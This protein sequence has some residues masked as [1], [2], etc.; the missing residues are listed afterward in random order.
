MLVPDRDNAV[1]FV[2]F[3]NIR[4][5]ISNG[6]NVDI[7][8]PNFFYRLNEYLARDYRIINTIIYDNFDRESGLQRLLKP[9]GYDCRQSSCNGKNA[10]D[11]E[12][13][14][15][16]VCTLYKNPGIKAYVLITSDR[17]IV[18]VLKEIKREGKISHLISSAIRFNKDTIAYADKHTYLEE[19]FSNFRLFNN[20][21]GLGSQGALAELAHHVSVLFYQS[22]IYKDSIHKEPISLPG[23][24]KALEK[25]LTYDSVTILDA[26]KLAG[27]LGLVEIYQDREKGMC[28][29]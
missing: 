28:I 3:E 23:Y 1:I 24:I 27:Q 29:R 8:N 7:V 10:A 4:R 18:P 20:K 12:I 6:Y 22:Q 16:I 25:T 5:I 26:F 14:V 9:N 13:T 19:I 17:D 2:D 15:D 21:I 11:I